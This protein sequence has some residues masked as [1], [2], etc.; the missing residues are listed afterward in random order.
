MNKIQR[1][2]LPYKLI[3]G[4]C[5]IIIIGSLGYVAKAADISVSDELI[6]IMNRVLVV[7]DEKEEMLGDKIQYDKQVFTQGVWMNQDDGC[8]YFGQTDRSYGICDVDGT[9]KVKSSGGAFSVMSG[10]TPG[11]EGWLADGANNFMY[12]ATNLSGDFYPLML[13]TNASSSP[14]NTTTELY[15]G[16]G[17][18]LVVEGELD[19]GGVVEFEGG[20][21]TFNEAGASDYDFTLES[22]GDEAAFVLDGSAD[23]VGIGVADPGA[24]LEIESTTAQLWLSYDSSYATTFTVGSAGQLTIAPANGAFGVTGTT[25]ASSGLVVDTDTLIVQAGP[26]TVGI[27]IA[28]PDYALEILSATAILKLDYS[29]NVNCTYVVSSG[30]DLITDCTGDNQSFAGDTI[31]TTGNILGANITGSGDLSAGEVLYVI[32]SGDTVG[33]GTTTPGAG[34]ASLAVYDEFE[35]FDASSPYDLLVELKDSAT[36]T[37][38]GIINVYENDTITALISGATAED[39]YIDTDGFFYDGSTDLIGISTT[40]PTNSITVFDDLLVFD[41]DSPYDKLVRLYDSSDDGLIQ[42][43]EN[44]TATVQIAGATGSATYFDTNLLYID[45]SANKVYM[46]TSTIGSTEDSVLTVMEGISIFDASAGYDPLFHFIDAG[47]DALMKIY[48]NGTQTGQIAGATGSDTYFDTDGFFLDGS[49]DRVGLSSSTPSA[50]LSVGTSASATTTFD[51][52]KPCFRF[53]DEAGTMLYYWPCTG[54]NCLSGAAWATST[55]SCY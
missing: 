54:A 34:G 6:D 29:A 14:A 3:I 49:T 12:P 23:K 37:D 11:D 24:K 52:A 26:D 30:G 16:G 28:D 51:F 21:F 48:E 7:L 38:S 13:G 46:A 32:D 47:D 25:T 36:D 35:L 5:L 1:T 50:D 43:Y 22:D 4:L 53:T 33:I 31:T 45:G 44:N 41:A 19:V 15:I 39:S 2:L 18:G 9:M 10:T 17:G 55:T 8:I 20:D 27:N 40:T 42:V